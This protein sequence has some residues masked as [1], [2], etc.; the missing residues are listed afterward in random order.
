MVPRAHKLGRYSSTQRGSCDSD[1]QAT[2]GVVP[3]QWYGEAST[4][5]SNTPRLID[6]GCL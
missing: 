3:K 2:E 6:S 5:L 4:V 1:D